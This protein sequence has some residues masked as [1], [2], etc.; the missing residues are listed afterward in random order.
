MYRYGALYDLKQ[1]D[2]FQTKPEYNAV[3][4]SQPRPFNRS[5][6]FL[7]CEGGGE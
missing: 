2:F 7:S 3:I 6:F 4:G 5:V 1:K